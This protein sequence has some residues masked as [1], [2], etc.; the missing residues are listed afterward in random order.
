MYGA[1]LRKSRADIELEKNS[2][3]DTLQRHR[4]IIKQTAKN[5][6][7]TIDRWFEEVVSGET[8]E[9]R[10][11]VQKMLL[12]VEQDF[13]E[14]ILVVDVDRLARGDTADQSRISKAFSYS[15]TKRVIIKFKIV[16]IIIYKIR[17][18]ISNYLYKSF[19]SCIININ[20]WNKRN[21]FLNICIFK[22]PTFKV[23]LIFVQIIFSLK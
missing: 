10:P 18:I 7:I 2:G 22:V 4:D 23:I 6:N 15:N 5:M 19:C 16:N 20:S 11:E 12:E 1:Y 17:H 8:I 9:A 21:T 3:V 13:Y 14:G